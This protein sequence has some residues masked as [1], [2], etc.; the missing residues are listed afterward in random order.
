MTNQILKQVR[1]AVGNLNPQEVR[2]T[3]ERPLAIR[4]VASG[5]AG[6]AAMEGYLSPSGISKKK[7]LEQAQALFRADASNAPQDFDLMIREA[8]LPEPA[9]A[10]VFDPENPNRLVADVL[11]E[12]EELGLPLARYFP[13]FRPPVVETIISGVSKENALFAIATALPNI[14]PGLIELPWAVAEISS[15]TAFLTVNQIRMLF[16][17]AGASDRPLGYRE[18]RA[19][20]ASLIAGAFGWRA[21]ARELAGKIPF[22]AGLVPKAAVA[23][24]GTYVVGRSAERLYRIGYGYT[25]EERR[26]VYGEALERGK[27]YAREFLDRRKRHSDSSS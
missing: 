12:R 13:P 15:D 16:L 20:I 4:L 9:D 19:E 11:R 26:L 6:Y 14:A 18:Q 2:E 27:E 10:F 7:R 23:F 17:L 1:E 3:A 24:A 5:S 21:L 25:R 22:G 8:G